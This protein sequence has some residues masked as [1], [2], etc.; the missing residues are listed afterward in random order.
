M[1]C[2]CPRAR[3]H[4]RCGG[5]RGG[6]NLGWLRSGNRRRLR[7]RLRRGGLRLGILEL[8]PAL[9]LV[10]PWNK[11]TLIKQDRRQPQEHRNDKPSVLHHL[12]SSRRVPRKLSSSWIDSIFFTVFSTS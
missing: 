10:Q 6:D 9:L 8:V 11:E 7:R 5:G 3:G 12:P 2:A 1:G 4:R